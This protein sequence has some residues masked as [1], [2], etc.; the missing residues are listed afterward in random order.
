MKQLIF[1]FSLIFF[2]SLLFAQK[3]LDTY[4]KT[5]SENNTSLKAAFSEYNAALEMLPQTKALPDPNVMFQYFTT[6]LLLEMG[7]Q[8]FNL[9]ASQTFPWLGQ[10][11]AKEQVA[12]E[13]A[14]AKYEEF[15]DKRNKLFK[16]VEGVYY[17]LYVQQKSVQITTENIDLLRSMRELVRIGF[18]GGK[19][20]FVNVLRADMQI[21][22][23]ENKLAYL[24]D[25]EWP[26]HTEFEKYLNAKI[27]GSISFPDTLWKENLPDS[28]SFM[29]DSIA[30]NNPSL[31]KIDFEI[32]AWEK[33][34]E[35][36]KKMGY[37]SFTLGATYMNMSKRSET[38]GHIHENG[39]DMFM[40]PEIGVMI[41]LYRKKYNA[42]VNEAKYKSE[43]A[44]Y[45]KV[46]MTNELSSELEMG[47]R[48]YLDAE[49]RIILYTRLLSLAK[50]ARELL[51]SN[52]SVAGND[53]EEVLR[54]QEQELMYALELEDARAMLDTSVA[55]INYLTG[56]Q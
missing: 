22:E 15:I 34:M 4:L 8:R 36:S 53:F 48:D 16:D 35:A 51:L 50:N 45:E 17:K 42:M 32:S 13:M 44:T 6:P 46:N 3:E 49:R 43:S 23:M 10:L 40:F 37:P 24:K 20:S 56:K 21:A 28:K 7:E 39:K 18:E 52:F 41:P 47:Y 19:G 25:S 5:A 11:K 9:S 31:K 14:K 1:F 29:L 26:L 54:M 2:N 12:A 27:L 33:Q 38:E 30:A 55:D